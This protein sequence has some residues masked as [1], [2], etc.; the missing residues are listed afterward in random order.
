M[1]ER[2]EQVEEELKATKEAL[3][4]IEED[5]LTECFDSL[6]MTVDHKTGRIDER[7]KE[8]EEAVDKTKKEELKLEEEKRKELTRK[9][10]TKRLTEAMFVGLKK[11]D[12]LTTRGSLEIKGG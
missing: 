3:D 10:M 12:L 11:A 2:L 6:K 8:L 1:L 9:K 4:K 7:L 5:N